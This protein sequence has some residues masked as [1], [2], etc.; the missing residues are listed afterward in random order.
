M[1]DTQERRGLAGGQARPWRT[2][3]RVGMAASQPSF[4]ALSPLSYF[5]VQ[6]LPPSIHLNLQA[7]GVS[8]AQPGARHPGDARAGELGPQGDHGIRSSFQLLQRACPPKCPLGRPGEA[9]RLESQ[10]AGCRA[11]GSEPLD[12]SQ[13]KAPG[14]P[15]EHM[16]GNPHSR[17][18]SQ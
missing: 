12:P 8:P 5:R 15:G 13:P 2:Q 1:D 11:R 17:G 9:R 18:L 4:L 14:W 10:N 6:T 16:Q 7:G 3:T